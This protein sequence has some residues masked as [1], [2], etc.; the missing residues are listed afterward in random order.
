MV[1]TLRYRV[2]GMQALCMF[3]AHVESRHPVQSMQ[4]LMQAPRGILAEHQ[5][6][7][8]GQGEGLFIG[9]F[10]RSLHRRSQ[11]RLGRVDQFAQPDVAIC[12][13]HSQLR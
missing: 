10:H 7:T 1:T 13:A 11:G 9:T 2:V 12:K 5:V 6:L 4:G 8:I 3:H